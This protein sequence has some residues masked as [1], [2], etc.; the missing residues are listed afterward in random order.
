MDSATIADNLNEIRRCIDQA[1]MRSQREPSAV[2]LVAVSKTFPVASVREAY[3]AG[4][5][6]FGESRYQEAEPKIE[7][8][9]THC[10]WHFIGRVQRNKVRKIVQH[11]EVIHAVDSLKLASYING[12]AQELGKRPKLFFQI[13]ISN[14]DTKGGFSASDIRACCGELM[15]LG[16]IQ[17]LGLMCI[18]RMED[19]DEAARHWFRQMRELRDELERTYDVRLPGLSMGMSDDFELAVEE[20]ATHV[21]VGSAIFGTR[22]YQV[23]GELGQTRNKTQ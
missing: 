2:E 14:E 4:Q 5:S 8:M 12:V 15:A 19:S 3:A 7:A 17:P 22:A 11:F 20:G 9:E 10:I 16:H 6:I 18:P 21:R 1:C 13:N 23:K